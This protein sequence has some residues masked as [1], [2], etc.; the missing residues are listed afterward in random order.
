MIARGLDVL[1]PDDG[2]LVVIENVGPG[3]PGALRSRRTC[4]VAILSVTEGD[5]KPAKYPH[6]FAA[7]DLLLVNKIDLLPYVNFDVDACIA[8]ARKVNPR[9]EAIVVSAERREPRGAD[10]WIRVARKI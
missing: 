3:L 2:S 8:H 4:E 7:S 1:A 6:M 10:D 5:E 9:L